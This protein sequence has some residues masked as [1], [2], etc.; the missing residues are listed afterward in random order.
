[1]T[2]THETGIFLILDK[3]Y[4]DLIATTT[5]RTGRNEYTELFHEIGKDFQ[6]DKR[7]TG[8]AV[9]EGPNARMRLVS[10][11]FI[12]EIERFIDSTISIKKINPPAENEES[13]TMEIIA[14]R[15]HI[16]PLTL[17]TLLEEQFPLPKKV[18]SE[19]IDPTESTVISGLTPD[20]YR[21]AMKEWEAGLTALQETRP[22]FSQLPDRILPDEELT[23]RKQVILTRLQRLLDIDPHGPPFVD[24]HDASLGCYINWTIKPQLDRDNNVLGAEICGQELKEKEARSI[25]IVLPQVR[26]P[27][28]PIVGVDNWLDPEFF[29]R[30]NSELCMQIAEQ[31]F[32][33]F[34]IPWEKALGLEPLTEPAK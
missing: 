16:E 14:E 18:S 22:M 10:Q 6:A 3:T 13:G 32:D 19:S 25:D 11:D 12:L 24:T 15:S 1:M 20:K 9:S 34:L 30:G 31:Y 8:F 33:A 5:E 2:R 26:F 23:A 7:I 27:S 21:I 4:K 28:I 17:C 29:S